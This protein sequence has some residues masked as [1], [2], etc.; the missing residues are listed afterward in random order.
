MRSSFLLT[1]FLFLVSCSSSRIDRKIDDKNWDALSGETY[2]RW[3]EKRLQG[4]ADEVAKCYQGETSGA[5][6]NFRKNFLT[7][8]ESPYYWLHIGN[9]FFMEKSWSKA[10]FYY[11]LGLESERPH[12]KSI[13]LNN[14]G[15]L[16]FKFEQ[17][18]QGRDYLEKAIALLPAHKVPRFNLS[19]LYLQFGLYHRAIE[20]LGHECFRGDKDLDVY[21]SLANAHLFKGD[22]ENAEKYFRMI[23]QNFKRR[24]DIAA[25]L[26]LLQ[27]K[28]GQLKEAKDT[29][30]ERERSHVQQLTAVSQKIEK[31]LLQWMKED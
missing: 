2:L 12:I 21:F 11:R 24:E 19:Q 26:A 27:L 6:E 28:K 9:C 23:P 17:W 15:L 10:Q 25:T 8:S 1:C 5:L 13:A 16:S 7:K 20:V 14:L 22:L 3:G 4:V 30:R 18:E 29:M 31:I